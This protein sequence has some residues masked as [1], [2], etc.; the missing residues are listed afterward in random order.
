MSKINFS[1]PWLINDNYISVLA[2]SLKGFSVNVPSVY[3][4]RIDSICYDAAYNLVNGYFSTTDEALQ[5]FKNEVAASFPD[6][7]I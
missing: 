7:K 2:D 1:N 5:Y 3:D 6:I 4:S